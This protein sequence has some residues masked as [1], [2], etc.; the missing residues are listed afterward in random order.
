MFILVNP[1]NPQP[2]IGTPLGILDFNFGIRDFSMKSPI[3]SYLAL[4]GSSF[5]KV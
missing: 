5:C 3:P 2:G 1:Q 4:M